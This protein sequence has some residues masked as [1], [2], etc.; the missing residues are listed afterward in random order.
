MV[1]TLIALL[2]AAYLAFQARRA[3]DQP[4][5]RRAFGL[6]AAGLLVLA[7]YNAAPAAGIA[8]PTAIGAISLIGLALMIGAAVSYILAL[9][10]GEVAA[11]HR[12]FQAEMR[13]E[14]KRRQKK[15]GDKTEPR[16]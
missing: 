8:N 7:I 11:Q 6:A 5:R 2:L 3:V 12:R 1:R 4:H 16:N 15:Q 10:A 14:V 13:E 9:R